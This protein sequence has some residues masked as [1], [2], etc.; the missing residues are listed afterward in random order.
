MS[1]SKLRAPD[2]ERKSVLITGGCGF[3][4]TNL[5][6]YL[7]ESGYKLR[8]LDNLST[9]SRIWT[10]NPRAIL[11]TQLTHDDHAVPIVDLVI[12]DIRHRETLENAVDGIDVVVH[13]AA[14][15]SV[16]DSLENPKED[17]EINVNGT[18]NL[19]EA[20]RRN[21]VD[22][23]IFASS[24]A[25]VGEQAAPVNEAMA[26]RPLSHYGA[27]KL[28]GE[29]L[30]SAYHFSFGLKTVSLRFANCYGPHSEHTDSVITRFIEWAQEAKPLVIYGDGDQTRDFIHVNDIC[31]AI[32]LCVSASGSRQPTAE[33]QLAQS[34]KATER[35]PSTQETHPE[36]TAD[37]WG[38]VLQ[39]A[40]GVETTI[41]Q[42]AQLI[43]EIAE[44]N[45]PISSQRGRQTAE[46]RSSTIYELERR[47]EIRSNCCDI[48]RAR[49]TLGFQPQV[50]LRDGLR[51]LWELLCLGSTG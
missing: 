13:L 6:K 31:Q 42:L 5:V 47:G 12:G 28:A 37:F 50:T 16:M 39:I 10:R 38:G 11:S 2:P 15:T 49:A 17:W 1:N 33:T 18:L 30:C 40:T 14:H 4:G 24:N 21:G 35:I 29:A 32:H 27:S 45:P 3:I 9:I 25:A 26:P 48:R 46:Y 23:F 51:R 34:S 43:Q 20:S 41:N 8:I 44:E 36:V 22:E 19:L 7:S